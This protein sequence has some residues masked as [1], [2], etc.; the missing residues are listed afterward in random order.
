M[1]SQECIPSEYNYENF[2]SW[3]VSRV[4]NS[5]T[6]TNVNSTLNIDSRSNIRDPLFSMLNVGFLDVLPKYTFQL[7]EDTLP[8]RVENFED[9]DESLS[10]S[11]PMVKASLYEFPRIHFQFHELNQIGWKISS[12]G[13]WVAVFPFNSDPSIDLQVRITAFA[14]TKSLVNYPLTGVN[15]YSDHIY[16]INIEK[17]DGIDE[18]TMELVDQN[19]KVHPFLNGKKRRTMKLIR[20]LA[21]PT[22]DNKFTFANCNNSKSRSTKSCFFF[23]LTSVIDGKRFEWF[24]K[25]FSIAS[26]IR[27]RTH[28]NKIDQ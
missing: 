2:T 13:E 22:P 23:R 16:R 24:S 28:Q 27:S 7:S 21:L 4:T 10:R 19:G 15:F 8:T 17:R 3:N 9:Q 20:S 5:N 12:N 6:L 25:Y 18:I 11:L 14:N 1:H 26:K